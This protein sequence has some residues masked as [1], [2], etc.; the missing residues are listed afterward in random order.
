MTD[1]LHLPL[2]PAL[3]AQ[4]DLICQQFH[5]ETREEAAELL[6]KRR[7]GRAARRISQRGRA[8]YLIRDKKG[9]A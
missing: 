6:L 5:L 4:L 8:L 1:E 3:A 7:L 9:K 2:D